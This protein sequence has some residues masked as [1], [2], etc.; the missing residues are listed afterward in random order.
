MTA[1]GGVCARCLRPLGPDFE[2]VVPES[3]SGARPALRL[4]PVGTPDCRPRGQGAR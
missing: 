3:A 4:H 2:T 1:A